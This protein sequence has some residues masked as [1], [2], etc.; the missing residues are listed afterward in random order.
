MLCNGTAFDQKGLVGTPTLQNGKAHLVL[1]GEAAGPPRFQ[2]HPG[3]GRAFKKVN[4]EAV[5]HVHAETPQAFCEDALV[6]RTAMPCE[7]LPQMIFLFCSRRLSERR[8]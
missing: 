2:P 3:T 7:E 1:F 8:M 4:I 6:E 5:C